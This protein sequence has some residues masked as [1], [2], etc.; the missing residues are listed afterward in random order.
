ML[1]YGIGKQLFFRPAPPSRTQKFIEAVQLRLNFYTEGWCAGVRMRGFLLG[2]MRQTIIVG[3]KRQNSIRSHRCMCMHENQMVFVIILSYGFF[4]PKQQ[5][6]KRHKNGT[7]DVYARGKASRHL[8][9]SLALAIL[10]GAYYFMINCW[11][12]I[13]ISFFI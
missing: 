8:A 2:K 4:T 10:M 13:K 6:Q 1:Y 7:K 12:W 3:K 11:G 9:R 5:Q